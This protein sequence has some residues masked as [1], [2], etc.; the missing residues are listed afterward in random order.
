MAYCMR[1]RRSPLCQTTCVEQPDVH[2]RPQ[3][4]RSFVRHCG[5]HGALSQNNH[6]ILPGESMACTNSGYDKPNNSNSVVDTVTW[7]GKW[8]LPSNMTR[9]VG[10]T[11]K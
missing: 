8:L 5:N 3:T 2:T 9:A 4:R 7:V 10:S 1:Q 11:L 6:L